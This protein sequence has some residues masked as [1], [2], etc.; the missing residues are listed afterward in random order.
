MADGNTTGADN[1]ATQSNGS[2]D[3]A[4][5]VRGIASNLSQQAGE[6]VRTFA[7]DGKTRA[8][9]ALDDVAKMIEDAAAQVEEKLGGQFGGYTRTAASQVSGFAE[10]LRGKEV[11]DLI[12]DARAF[13]QKSPAI[14]I[15]AAAAVGFVL[16]RVLRSGIDSSRG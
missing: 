1:G 15:G 3:A 4:S 5:G 2:P 13:V 7:D 14:A 9:G 16:S 11:D 8:T 12:E 6:K 10:T